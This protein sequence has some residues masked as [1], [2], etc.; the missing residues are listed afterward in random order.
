MTR[1]S[2]TRTLTVVVLVSVVL[3]GCSSTQQRS[4]SPNPETTS[5]MQ[6]AT[7]TAVKT[8]TASATATG[9]S[10]GQLVVSE[11]SEVP[12]NATVTNYTDPWVPSSDLLVSGFVEASEENTTWSTELTAEQRTRL[13][14]GFSDV[15]RF[16]GD[17]EGYYV[18]FDGTVYRVS[19]LTYD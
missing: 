14:E 1:Q 18:R 12:E 2:V 15:P 5:S 7:Y 16:E 4:A 19:I 8:A 17:R 9:A 3:A 10:P 13:L 6:T 11:V